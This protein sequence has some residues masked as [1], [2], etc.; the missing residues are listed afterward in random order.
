M[1][2]R[3]YVLLSLGGGITYVLS[4][5]YQRSSVVTASRLTNL[6]SAWRHSY[7]LR[8]DANIHTETRILN[9]FHYLQGFVDFLREFFGRFFLVILFIYILA[10]GKLL[11][12]VLT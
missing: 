3:G 10:A 12:W 6:D 2:L 1:L 11:V 9:L 7:A 5:M 8:F 4:F